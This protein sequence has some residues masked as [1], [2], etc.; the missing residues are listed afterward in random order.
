MQLGLGRLEERRALTRTTRNI[1]HPWF[2]LHAWSSIRTSTKS[3][4]T[5][6]T[7]LRTFGDGVNITSANGAGTGHVAL[8]ESLGF[9]RSFV[10]STSNLPLH[11]VLITDI[12]RLTVL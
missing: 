11:A 7:E 6:G 12:D 2:A 9:D 1:E 3:N 5:R 8:C 10:W 4:P